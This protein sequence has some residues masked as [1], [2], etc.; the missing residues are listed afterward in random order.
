MP[1]K[2]G[3]S[4]GT[5]VE[6]FKTEKAAGK[7][8]DQSWAIAFNQARKAGGSFPRKK[9]GKKKAKKPVHDSKRE[10]MMEV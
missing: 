9:K 7:P 1:L 4:K 5:I 6:N 3:K 8:E 2:I 10:E